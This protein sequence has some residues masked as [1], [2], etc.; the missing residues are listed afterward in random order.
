MILARMLL[1]DDLSKPSNGHN[2]SEVSPILARVR[3]F[4]PQIAAANEALS[5]VQCPSSGIDIVNV[6]DD[7]HSDE[8]DTESGIE[9]EDTDQ[10]HI[11]IDVSVFKDGNKN[12]SRSSD[13]SSSE[14][15]EVDG[16]LPKAFRT[17]REDDEI[18]SVAKK[19]K[20]RKRKL[21]EEVEEG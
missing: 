2:M 16:G 21:I 3:D 11:E 15:S 12:S 19:Q 1:L 5:N 17:S 18:N 9:R 14:D 4:L 10:P 8:S 13:S 6:Q 7:Q 20:A